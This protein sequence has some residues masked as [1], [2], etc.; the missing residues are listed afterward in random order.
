MDWAHTFKMLL[1]IARQCLMFGFPWNFFS[2]KFVYIRTTIT[3]AR[4]VIFIE[5]HAVLNCCCC[6]CWR[7]DQLWLLIAREIGLPCRDCFVVW[8]HMNYLY[9]FP[10]VKI[11]LLLS[12]TNMKKFFS[13]YVTTGKAVDSD[14]TLFECMC[15]CLLCRKKAGIWKKRCP[16][17]CMLIWSSGGERDIHLFEHAGTPFNTSFSV[18]TFVRPCNFCFML[19]YSCLRVIDVTDMV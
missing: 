19:K 4:W 1:Y 10:I 13:A 15:A 14:Q 11:K 6:C 8:N 17:L 7:C 3:A 5:R 16:R 18:F 12:M 2:S 9:R